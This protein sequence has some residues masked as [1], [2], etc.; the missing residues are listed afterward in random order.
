MQRE[1]SHLQA[2]LNRLVFL[3]KVTGH[4]NIIKDHSIK[5][6]SMQ[7]QRSGKGFQS[8]KRKNTSNL[9][10]HEGVLFLC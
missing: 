6:K 8:Y 1:I 9:P 3:K 2:G 4:N 10:N 7:A 5:V